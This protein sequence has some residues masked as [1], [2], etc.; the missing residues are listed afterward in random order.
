MQVELLWET[1]FNW[2]LNKTNI[3]ITCNII[4]LLLGYLEPYPNPIPVNTIN[5]ITKSY[6]VYCSRNNLKLNIY[7]LQTRIKSAYETYEFIS[8]KNNK[9]IILITSE[10]L[11][12]N[13]S[14]KITQNPPLSP[15]HVSSKTNH[16]TPVQN[17]NTNFRQPRV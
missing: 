7:N 10:N 17:N 9:K 3:R 11:L 4:P 2:I 16:P 14:K 5:M 6:I 1:L 13:N 8:I 15:Q 12:N